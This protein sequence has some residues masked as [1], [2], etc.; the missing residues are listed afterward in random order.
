MAAL[1]GPQTQADHKRHSV[2][3]RQ[4]G[5]VGNGQHNVIALISIGIFRKHVIISQIL[6]GRL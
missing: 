6:L 3:A 5:K 1:V 2:T 4:K